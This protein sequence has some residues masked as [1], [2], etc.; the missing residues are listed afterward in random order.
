MQKTFNVWV[1]RDGSGRAFT[2][3]SKKIMFSDGSNPVSIDSAS[4]IIRTDGAEVRAC[5]VSQWLKTLNIERGEIKSF[6]LILIPD[7]EQPK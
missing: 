6:K 4:P 3:C 7:E 1:R 2:I 5:D